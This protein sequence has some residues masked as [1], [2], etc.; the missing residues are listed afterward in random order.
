[1]EEAPAATALEYDPGCYLCPGNARAGGMR[2]PSYSDTFVFDND[3]AAI[4]PEAGP[5]PQESDLLSARPERGLCRVVCFSPRHDL[6]LANMPAE[7]VRRVVDVWTSQYSELAA[8]DYVR[9]VQIFENRG[10]MMGCSNPHPHGQIWSTSE[11]P[12]E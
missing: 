4:R 2:N 1:M 8:L 5:V 11:L 10:A 6:T 12:N 7:G 3:F 9:W